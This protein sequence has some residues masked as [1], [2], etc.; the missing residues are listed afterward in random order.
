MAYAR[1]RSAQNY[2]LKPVFIDVEVDTAKGLYSFSLVG[3]P[4]AATEEAKDR[5]SSAL[6]NSG[7]DNPK[8]KNEKVVVSLAPAQIKKEGTQFDLAIA[9]GYLAA[10]E[11][12]FVIPENSLYIG[13]LGLDG[14]VHAVP[15]VVSITRFARE[16]GCREIFVPNETVREAALISS[17]DVYGVSSLKELVDHI[18]G[19]RKIQP[20]KPTILKKVTTTG[21]HFDSIIGQDT[22]K[23]ALMI[24]ASGGHNIILYGPPGTGKTLLARALNSLLPGLTLEESL[25]VSEIHSI[26]RTGA[27][28]VTHPPF[29]SPHHTASYTALVGGGSIPKPGEITLAHKGVLFLDEFPEFERRVIDALREPLEEQT[30]TVSRVK[31]SAKFPADFLLVA[32][33][34]PCQC[35][36]FGSTEK[37]CICSAL[38]LDRYRKKISGP[39]VDRIDM[40]VEVQ[41]VAHDRLLQ[42]TDS[43]SKYTHKRVSQDVDRARSLQ[44]KR[45]EAT[46]VK[47]NARIPGALIG[48]LCDI[49]PN[50]RRVLERAGQTL[51]LSARAF[52]RATRLARTIADLEGSTPVMEKHIL[53]ALSY[54]LKLEY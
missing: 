1:V 51:G 36:N 14:S 11:T 17:V 48:K 33:M 32:A 21:E 8:S 19:I 6:K 37:K 50:A 39:I 52:H 15:G 43:E 20:A 12:T 54:R 31:G 34:N 4:D 35:G 2:L 29:R 53:E 3:L 44:S 40:W 45:L 46:K 47:T 41:A 5:V 27:G 25:E 7:L 24:A 13:E 26:A 23:R 16:K 22:A 38:S 9:L 42:E 28:L 18:K 10:R 30:V 49:D